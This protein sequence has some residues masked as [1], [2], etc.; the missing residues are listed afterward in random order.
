MRILL[1]KTSSFGDVVHT[2]PALSDAVHHHPGLRVDWAVEPDF[3]AITRL[4]PSV[5]RVIPVSMR[6]LRRP[7]A[8]VLREWLTAVGLMRGPHYDAVIDAQGLLKTAPLTLLA[9][10]PRHGFDRASAR[11]GAAALAYDHTH[12]VSRKLHAIARTRALFAAA[13]GYPPSESQPNS[14]LDHLRSTEKAIRRDIVFVHAASWQTKIWPVEAWRT[15]A[16]ELTRTGFHILLPRYGLA[17]TARAEQI[18][19]GIAGC[20]VLNPMGLEGLAQRFAHACGVVS[21]DTGLAHL[22]AAMNVPVVTLFGPTSSGLT[23]A[24]GPSAF[25][26]EAPLSICPH[27][28]CLAREC[29]LTSAQDPP[30]CLSAIA[31]LAV[32][33]ALRKLITADNPTPLR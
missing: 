1:I 26:L 33:N 7:N 12:A 8:T 27:L 11:E 32:A 22:A 9:R 29:R 28:P 30:P 16:L 3:A 25:N 2:F 14:G 5:E 20:E 17:E 31:P 4:H 18:A 23:G 6:A 19:E 24:T 21:L 15:L 13:L 10:G